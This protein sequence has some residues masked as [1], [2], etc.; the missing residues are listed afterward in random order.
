VVEGGGETE[1]MVVRGS[2]GSHGRGFS[3]R[4]DLGLRRWR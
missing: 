2:G 4:T 3:A 1:L